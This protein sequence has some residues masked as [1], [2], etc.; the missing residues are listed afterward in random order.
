MKKI[1]ITLILFVLSTLCWAAKGPTDDQLKNLCRDA[2][3]A[4][5][6][7]TNDNDKQS[8]FNAE[9]AKLEKKCDM[10]KIT[11][12]QITML[13]E[14][15]GLTLDR[16]LRVWLEPTLTAK[17]EADAT[18]AFYLWKYMPENDGF[19]HGPKETAAFVKFL[20][21]KSLQNVISSNEDIVIDIFN[22]MPTMKDANWHTAGYAKGIV[23]L[24]E[25]KLPES[26]MMECVKVFNSAARVDNFDDNEQGY[27]KEIR[28]KLRTLCVNTYKSLATTL[29][30][31]R[32][33]KIC[34][35]H[36]TY[37]EGP[38]A[39]GT[40]VGNTAPELH[41]LKMWQQEGDN[42]AE[43]D[44][45]TLGDLKGKVIMLDFWG[46]KCVPCLLSFPEI[47][48]MQEQ[49]KG[50]DVIILGVTSLQGYFIDTPNKRTI[51]CRNNPEKELSLFP[52]Y[53]KAMGM[54]WTVGISKEDVM[55]TDYGALAIPHVV[56]IDKKGIVRYNAVNASK[57]EKIQLIEQ[58]I[59]E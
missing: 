49:L 21:S 36:I 40:L 28:E 24:M 45:K 1:T 6:S 25:C 32:K 54:T 48:E 22:A 52:D 12:E 42:V 7:C 8:A 57:E 16:Q 37:L 47:V 39:C 9:A 59:N 14:A 30:S 41:F 2:A 17:S 23:R 13:F 34:N 46:T 56:L 3:A 29:E 31:A 27:T 43:R 20:S 33:K 58:L 50:K 26:A 44:V 10:T 53:M 4:I 15:G 11:G 35:E 51:Q 19:S 5:A 38:F 18:Y 55:N